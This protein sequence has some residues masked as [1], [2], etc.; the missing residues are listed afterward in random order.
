MTTQRHRLADR[1]DDCYETP[2][3]AVQAL[4]RVEQIPSV[5]WEPC[6]GPG[7]IVRELRATRRKV[8]ATDLVDYGCPDSESRIDFLLETRA[9]PGVEAIVSNF[10]FKLAGEMVEHALQLVPIVIVLARLTFLESERRSNILDGGSLARVHIF[11]SRLPMMHRRN[12]GGAR[13]TSQVPYAWFVWRRDH[14]GPT[15]LDRISR[16]DEYD[17]DDDIRKSVAV[18][19]AAIRQRVRSGG[20][21][22]KYVT[23][24]AEGESR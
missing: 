4:L 9:P 10:P 24:K 18:A 22:W 12:W 2:A 3:V 6:C 17:A 13:S 5:V 23:T 1:G 19:F 21:G 15:V 14:R 11:R 16:R 7:S 8:Y 20:K